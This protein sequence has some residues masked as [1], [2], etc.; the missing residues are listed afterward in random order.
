M[1]QPVKKLFLFVVFSFPSF[2]FSQEGVKTTAAVNKVAGKVMLVAFEPKMYMSDVDHNI[3]KATKWTFDQIREYFRRQLDTQIKLKL[4]STHGTIVSFYSDSIKMAKD[5]D[6]VY[7]NTS[8]SFDPID[9]PTEPTAPATKKNP[10]I[11]NGQLSVEINNDKKFMNTKILNTEVLPYLTNKYKSEYFVFINEFDMKTNPD[12][13]DIKTDSYQR[14][15]TVHYTI[16]DKN[17]KLIAAGVATNSYSSRVND[18]KKIVAQCFPA[19]ATI[20]ANK[21]NAIANQK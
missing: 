11:H 5:L 4:Q 10:N 18:P 9:K 6:Y 8:L 13:Y 20:I 3:N 14:E 17:G 12:S 19:I 7:N 15:I 16:M 1:N 2:L 21:C